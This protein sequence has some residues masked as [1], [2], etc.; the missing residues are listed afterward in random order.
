MP[1]P[2]IWYINGGYGLNIF[3]MIYQPTIYSLPL[4]TFT[5]T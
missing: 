3:S 1:V 5:I 2:N 4:N